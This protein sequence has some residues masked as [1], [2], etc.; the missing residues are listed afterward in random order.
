MAISIDDILEAYRFPG[1]RNPHAEAQELAFGRSFAP[2]KNSPVNGAISWQG[3]MVRPTLG[4]GEI[5]AGSMAKQIAAVGAFK[6]TQGLG[7]LLG[8]NRVGNTTNFA[9]FFNGAHG[10]ANNQNGSSNNTQGWISFLAQR[11]GMFG[12]AYWVRFRVFL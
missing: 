4:H 12:V 7:P 11:L 6:S 1:A 9:D 10:T 5:P 3:E 2:S 8:Q